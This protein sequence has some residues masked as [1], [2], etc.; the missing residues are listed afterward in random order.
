[1]RRSTRLL[2]ACLLLIAATASAD[3]WYV[4]DTEGTIGGTGA[5]DDPF[6]TIQ[7]GID[8]AAA[9]GDE[10]L[11]MPGTYTGAGNRD[12]ATLGKAVT[13][14]GDSGP[15]LTVIDVGSGSHDGFFL[16]DTGEDQATRIEGL[17]IRNGR[18]GIRMDLRGTAPVLENLVIEGHIY[19]GLRY[20]TLD[21]SLDALDIVDCVFRGHPSDAV[22]LD[23]ITAK[24]ASRRDPFAILSGCHFED[25]GTGIDCIRPLAPTCRVE[26]SSFVDNGKATWGSLELLRCE[27]TGG[28]MGCDGANQGYPH[29][30][31]ATDCTF[32]G[33]TDRVVGRPAELLATGC[34]FHANIGD[35]HHGGPYEESYQSLE[36]VACDFTANAGSLELRGGQATLVLTDCLYAGNGGPVRFGNAYGAGSLTMTGC[37]LVGNA[38]DGVE[39]TAANGPATITGTIIVANG[40]GGIDWLPAVA[41]WSVDCSDVWNNSGGDYL[42]LPDQTGL[43]QNISGDP[44][45]C[46]AG[47][48]DY[49][50]RS[51]SPCLPGATGCGLMGARDQGCTASAVWHV[52]PWGNDG[53]GTGSAVDPFQ[54]VQF[55]L[56]TAGIGD[57]VMVLDGVYEE[58]LE[59]TRGVTLMSASDD[60]SLC[61]LSAAAD[62]RVAT[63]HT[64]TDTVRIRGFD[65]SGGRPLQGDYD[66][67]NPGGGILTHGPPLVV[68]NCRIHDNATPLAET[69]TGGGGIHTRD[70]TYLR[71]VD[72]EIYDNV[73]YRGG[74]LLHRSS[75]GLD[76]FGC[77]VYANH[78]ERQ[79]GGIWILPAGANSATYVVAGSTVVHNTA[80]VNG[81]GLEC[82]LADL[83]LD[84]T[85]VA[86]NTGGSAQVR[87]RDCTGSLSCNDLYASGDGV[88]YDADP[89]LPHPTDI[90]A[91]PRFCLEYP[92]D[93]RLA[94]DSPCAADAGPCGQIG[95][96]GV[97]CTTTAAPELAP[98]VAVLHPPRPNPFNARVI[99]DFAM[100]RPG[101]AQVDVVDVRGA[102]VAT[103]VDEDFP[104]GEHS[105]TWGGLDSRGRPAAAGVYLVRL[106]T[107]DGVQIAR[108]SLVK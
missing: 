18:Y 39:V 66:G 57:T 97:G 6:L 73:S 51:D 68:E 25:N 10:V 8:A 59:I 36:F 78:C 71:L 55:G 56:D 23:I 107:G 3:S 101:R 2:C 31:V 4:S 27:V 80:G 84:N 88:D 53:T 106:R 15:E 19:A 104:M 65:V 29:H 17:T 94:A 79:G 40:G 74:G 87:L 95:A 43:N 72:C 26:D 48:G 61:V 108:I 38:D 58:S 63:I 12:L 98:D 41:T 86:F 91:D 92:G 93:F 90:S 28:E 54:T 20:Q 100:V 42:G 37:T 50:L 69:G 44:V 76:I 89:F 62:R 22:H 7:Q 60:P 45:F 11:I 75:E 83:T 33:V 1:M 24:S 70:G 67:F 105:V 82:Y 46:D 5:I 35:I 34:V 47:A 103:V 13:V 96:H 16:N 99:L 77:L 102:V 9:T 64:A 21:A 30:I 49:S 85:I 14:R 32:T 52:A 81:S